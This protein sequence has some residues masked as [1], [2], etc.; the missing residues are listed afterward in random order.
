MTLRTYPLILLPSNP[1]PDKLDILNTSIYYRLLYS[2]TP[3]ELIFSSAL[4]L[5]SSYNFFFPLLMQKNRGAAYHKD[6][7]EAY[8]KFSN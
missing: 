2:I 5:T 4:F 7:Q 1:K 6:D 8:T 3:L